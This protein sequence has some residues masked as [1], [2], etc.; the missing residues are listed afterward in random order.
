MTLSLAQFDEVEGLSLFP[1]P[2]K[3]SF[4]ISK[5]IDKLDIYDISGRLVKSFNGRLSA[6]YPF[7]ISNLNS[8]VYLIKVKSGQSFFSTKLIKK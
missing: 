2:V 3:D 1:N 6:D 4:Y 7:D 8:S 5:T